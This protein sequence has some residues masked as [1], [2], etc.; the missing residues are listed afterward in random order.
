MQN[1]KNIYLKWFQLTHATPKSWK[2]DI[3]TDQGNY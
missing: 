2:N 3:K 1:Q